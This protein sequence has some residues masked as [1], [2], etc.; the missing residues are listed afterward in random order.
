MKPMNFTK[1]E[2]ADLQFAVSFRMVALKHDLARP[3]FLEPNERGEAQTDHDRLEILLGK[4][5][6]KER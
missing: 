2:L 4:L 1:E 3:D 6:R 5:C